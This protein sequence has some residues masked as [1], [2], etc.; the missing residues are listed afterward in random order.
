MHMFRV[1]AHQHYWNPVR[2]DYSWMSMDNPV[3]ARK[4]DTHDLAPELAAN[5]IDLTVLVQAA[6]TLHETEYMLGIA[7]TAKN[8]SAVVGWID[9]E[10]PRDRDALSCFSNHPKF[11]GGPA[12]D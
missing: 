12:D 11:V 9:F 3:L 7:D 6:A 4:Y 2:G 1:D 10:N 5:R 8:V